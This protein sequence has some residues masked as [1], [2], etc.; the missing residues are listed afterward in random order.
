[1]AKRAILDGR[2]AAQLLFRLFRE[3]QVGLAGDDLALTVID[4]RHDAAV[5]ALCRRLSQHPG[6]SL[7]DEAREVRALLCWRL[8]AIMGKLMREPEGL[9]GLSGLGRIDEAAAH[10]FLFEHIVGQ[11]RLPERENGK[12]FSSAKPEWLN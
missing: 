3:N 9:D 2:R 7:A 10:A 6:L 11:S 8:V 1:M 4:F 12:L 5:D